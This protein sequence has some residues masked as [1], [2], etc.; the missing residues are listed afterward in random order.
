MICNLGYLDFSAI[1]RCIMK[2]FD[3]LIDVVTEWCNMT[4]IKTYFLKAKQVYRYP[5]TECCFFFVYLMYHVLNYF[6]RCCVLFFVFIIFT[7]E[8]VAKYCILI[9]HKFELIIFFIEQEVHWTCSL[10]KKC[11]S[12]QPRLKKLPFCYLYNRDNYLFCGLFHLWKLPLN[13]QAQF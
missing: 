12:V 2:V 7:C 4:I 1:F 11:P 13:Y 3:C 9:F 5:D 8:F 10:R 6:E